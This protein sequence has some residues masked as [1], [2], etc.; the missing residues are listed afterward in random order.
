MSTLESDAPAAPRRRGVLTWLVVT[1]VLVLLSLVPW[2]AFVVAA[3]RIAQD[4]PTPL[5]WVGLAVVIAYGPVAI[6][7]AVAAWRA[8]RRGLHRRAAALTSVPMLGVVPL[9]VVVG[10]EVS[11][12]G[13][14]TDCCALPPASDTMPDTTSLPLDTVLPGG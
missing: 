5:G 2:I 9:L 3:P 12:W 7:C 10:I 6:A 4:E 11:H 14:P 13:E 8:Y 1:Q